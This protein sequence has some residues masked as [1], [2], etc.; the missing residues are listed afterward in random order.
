MAMQSVI[1]VDLANVFGQPDFQSLSP[2][3]GLGR[4]GRSARNDRFARPY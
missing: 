1:N 4:P 2:H 3:S